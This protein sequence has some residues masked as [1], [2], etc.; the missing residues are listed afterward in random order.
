MLKIK[1]NL[2]A[3]V[4]HKP[5]PGFTVGS[6][7]KQM[8]RA[9][10]MASEGPASSGPKKIEQSQ[11]H[12]PQRVQSLCPLLHNSSRSQSRG[13]PG[14]HLTKSLFPSGL[15]QQALKLCLHPTERTPQHSW[16]QTEAQPLTARTNVA[17][18]SLPPGPRI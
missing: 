16:T 4:T 12:T 15:A 5:D 14:T 17:N 10:R 13:S 7:P 2:P 9:P 1:F 8:R 18:S 11:G 6:Q 3:V